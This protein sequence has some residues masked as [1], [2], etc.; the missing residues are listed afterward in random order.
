MK[1]RQV[2]QHYLYQKQPYNQGCYLTHKLIKQTKTE[3]REFH[4]TMCAI[5]DKYYEEFVANV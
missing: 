1:E 3:I 5:Y 4:D 2:L